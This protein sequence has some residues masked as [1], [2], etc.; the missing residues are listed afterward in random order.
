M[1]GN[2][3]EKSLSAVMAV[4]VEFA[5]ITLAGCTRPFGDLNKSARGLLGKK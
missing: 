1:I 5:M 4:I 3:F 2:R